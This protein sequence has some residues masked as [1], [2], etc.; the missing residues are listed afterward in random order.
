MHVSPGGH[1]T[2]I[3]LTLGYVPKGAFTYLAR[4]VKDEVQVPVITAHV[5]DLFLAEKVLS[6]GHADFIAFGRQF[7]ADPEFPLKAREGRF[8]DIRP[9]I[10]CNQ[11][12]YDKVM[13]WQNVSCLMNPQVGREMEQDAGTTKKKKIIVIGGGPGGLK[14]AE[15]LAKRG[16]QVSLYEKEDRLGGNTVRHESC[17]Y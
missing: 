6:L 2:T 13:S 8:E 9:C 4:A 11:E 17:F 7:L 14:C 5:D 10:R 12:C 15:E 1:D 3:P 16:H